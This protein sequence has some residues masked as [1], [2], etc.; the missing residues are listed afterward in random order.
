M[1]VDF[2]DEIKNL[3]FDL[4]W[5]LKVRDPLEKLERKLQETKSKKLSNP[6]KTLKLRS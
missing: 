5:L 2:W 4:K 1:A 6:Q 3:N